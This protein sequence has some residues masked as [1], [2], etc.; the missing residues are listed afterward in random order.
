MHV[1]PDAIRTALHPE[2]AAVVAERAA[3]QAT[4]L[5]EMRVKYAIAGQRFAAPVPPDVSVSTVEIPCR[6]GAVAARCYLPTGGLVTDGLLVWAHGGGWIVGSAAGFERTAAQLA[7]NSHTRTLSIDYS[8]A[9]ENPFPR[10]LDEVRAVV[11]WVRSAEAATLLGH[12]PARIVV[13]GDSA[14]GNLIAVAA[15]GAAV[16]PPPLAGQVLAYPVTTRAVPAQDGVNSPMLSAE[17]LATS[18]RLYLGDDGPATPQRDFSPIHG[19]LAGL[20]PTLLVLAGLDI[21]HDDGAGYGR[22]LQE[23][24]V[25]TEVIAYPDLP[26]GF[27]EWTGRVRPSREAHAR[28]G[29]FVRGR[30]A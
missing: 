24:G 9:P 5:A 12:H 6:G 29:D 8:L 30:V 14:G 2:A 26:H 7:V 20:P 16:G 1:P 13:G 15:A 11:D 22:A 3:M 19:D 23:A 17:A 27:L 18:W 21:L 25:S 4:N 10:G 28:I